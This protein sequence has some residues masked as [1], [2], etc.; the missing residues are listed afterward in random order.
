MDVKFTNIFSYIS[1]IFK[2]AVSGIISKFKGNN[3]NIWI[4]SERG[5]E[6]RDNGFY[7][8][9][10]VKAYHPEISC[11]YVISS[12]STDYDKLH[13]YKDYLINKGSIRHYL[14]LHKASNLISTHIYGATPDGFRFKKLNKVLNLLKGKKIIF[15]Q[16]GI[17]KEIIPM[18]FYENLK[19][20]MFVSGA[21]GE[22]ELINKYYHFPKG[23]VKYT[24]LPRYDGLNSYSTKRQ[25]LFMPTWRLYLNEDNFCHSEYY[26]KVLSLLSSK[27][28]ENLLNATNYKF[29]FFPHLGIQPF[30]NDF[31]DKIKC[32]KII[33]ADL[34]YDVQTLLKESEILLTDY[35]SV[36]FDFAYMKKP[37]ISYHFDADTYYSRHYPKGEYDGSLFGLVAYNEDNLLEELRRIIDNG[38]IMDENYKANVDSFFPMR[39]DNNCK[40]V[41]EAIMQL[42]D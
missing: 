3:K 14:L 7:L 26:E 27:K 13:S 6:A 8:F 22:Y 42:K 29:V 5:N 30:I 37:I 41:F 28:L 31:K 11:Y 15:L 20:D 32:E 19:V 21:Q 2:Y 12:T 16:H 36:L 17:I 38:C 4:F 23:I 34:N 35:S 10:Y 40:R 18:L 25:I 24:G 39:D 9:K 1:I 33:F